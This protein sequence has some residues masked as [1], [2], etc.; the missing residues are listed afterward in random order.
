MPTEPSCSPLSALSFHSLEPACTR[1]LRKT[2]KHFLLEIKLVPSFDPWRIM[3]SDSKWKKLP[4]PKR[5]AE[6]AQ[7]SWTLF[8]RLSVPKIMCFLL[9]LNSS[10][11]SLLKSSYSSTSLRSALVG[12]TAT[13]DWTCPALKFFISASFKLEVLPIAKNFF[14]AFPQNC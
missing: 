3:N 9:S 2:N 13:M 4:H 11:F 12:P 5:F 8:V 14:S 6:K 10:K 7:H 1:E